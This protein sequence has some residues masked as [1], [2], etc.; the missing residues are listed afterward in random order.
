V[1]DHYVR[2]E[3]NKVAVHTAKSYRAGQAIL[4]FEPIIWRSERDC[5]T[6]EHPSG[7]HMFHPLL[8]RVTHSCS[9]NCRV[10][11][12]QRSLIALR[13]VLPGEPITFDYRTTEKR[14]AK[15]FLCRCGS[16]SCAGR[17]A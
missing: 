2:Q 13:D 10:S 11:F 7:D 12:V 16:S 8:A 9:P 6:V 3:G 15:P 5:E 4:R 14:L 17:L 1:T